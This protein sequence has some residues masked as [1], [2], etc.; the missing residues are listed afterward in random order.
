MWMRFAVTDK[1]ET[2]YI[3]ITADAEPGRG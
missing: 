2:P 3:T 1:A